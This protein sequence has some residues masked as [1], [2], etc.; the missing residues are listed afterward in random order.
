MA[1]GAVIGA[2]VALFRAR[3]DSAASAARLR[4]LGFSVVCAPVVEIVARPV[5][6]VK[7]RYDVVVAT[8]ANAFL[9]E[10]PVATAAPLFVVGAKAGR[11][12]E[13]RGW[14]L[15]AAPAPDAD[16]L[17]A[18]LRRQMAPGAAALYLA[19][20]DRK[21]TLE[22]A[23]GA[24]CSLEVVEAYAAEAREAWRPAEVRALAE[25][26]SA[27]HYSRRSAALASRLAEAAGL[28]EIFATMRH[29]CLSAD[30]AEPLQAIGAAE[31]L[32]ADAPD[33]PALFATLRQA[34]RLF[35]SPRPSR[36]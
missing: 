17:I 16:K 34:Q 20:R 3:D 4:W 33:E 36:I 14:R 29:V 32:V 18:T 22:A 5:T 2:R 27:L 1:K 8:S 26:A 12:A 7:T 15:A 23:L 35:P 19:G 24:I 10:A 31:V 9:N 28:A 25:C 6:P 11:A 30:V 13:K 21:R